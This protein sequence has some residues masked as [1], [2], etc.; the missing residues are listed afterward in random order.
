MKGEHD[1]SQSPQVPDP[2]FLNLDFTAW[3]FV[4]LFQL[5]CQPPVS[6]EPFSDAPTPC[7]PNTVLRIAEP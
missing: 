1:A 5:R 4:S 2:G 6:N 7:V 3:S